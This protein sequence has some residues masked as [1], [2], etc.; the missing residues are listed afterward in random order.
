MPLYEIEKIRGPKNR[1]D[2][3]P[4]DMGGDRFVFKR[5]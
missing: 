3:G 1:R 4:H 5:P 2:D